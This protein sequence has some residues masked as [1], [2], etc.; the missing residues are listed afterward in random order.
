MCVSL[1]N[2]HTNT[3]ISHYPVDNIPWIISTGSHL[4]GPKSVQSR[5]EEPLTW[6]QGPTGP[7]TSSYA[8]SSDYAA[9]EWWVSSIGLIAWLAGTKLCSMRHQPT[10]RGSILQVAQH[11][12]VCQP[13]PL[14]HQHVPSSKRISHSRFICSCKIQHIRMDFMAMAIESQFQPQ[15]LTWIMTSGSLVST[16]FSI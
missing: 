4:K 9:E 16:E 1:G 7:Q 15:S 8:I 5:P 13:P 10:H 6:S 11:P 3:H 12:P 2:V 14:P